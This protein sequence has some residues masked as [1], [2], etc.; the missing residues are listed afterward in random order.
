MSQPMQLPPRVALIR[1]LSQIHYNAVRQ[2]ET[3]FASVT[4]SD[5]GKALRGFQIAESLVLTRKRTFYEI[6]GAQAVPLSVEEVS[7]NY[8]LKAMQEKYR[9]AMEA[10]KTSQR[11]RRV[12]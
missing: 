10:W 5:R 4:T 11:R 7:A 12:S 1:W 8:N 2:I 3:S 6:R 9:T